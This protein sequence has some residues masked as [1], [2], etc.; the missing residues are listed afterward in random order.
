ML[1]HNPLH[2]LYCPSN[3]HPSIIEFALEVTISQTFSVIVVFYCQ[4]EAVEL[5]VVLRD[6]VN[7]LWKVREVRGA[8]REL[9]KGGQAGKEG[10]E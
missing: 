9:H 4:A 8:Q 1:S 5:R 6:T 7:Q 2:I 10:E 3:W